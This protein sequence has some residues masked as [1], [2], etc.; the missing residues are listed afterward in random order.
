MTTKGITAI[1]AA[2][3]FFSA[4][5][6]RL[7]LAISLTFFSL[8]AAH[9]QQSMVATLQYHKAELILRDYNASGR[10]DTDA[11]REQL[12]EALTYIGYALDEDTDDAFLWYAKAQV[13]EYL[14]QWDASLSAYKQ[15]FAIQAH[16]ES[17][18]SIA[19]I[20]IEQGEYTEAILMLNSVLSDAPPLNE[21]TF[22]LTEQLISAYIMDNQLTQASQLADQLVE[23]DHSLASS[24]LR[25]ATHALKDQ[26]AESPTDPQDFRSIVEGVFDLVLE[27]D[28]IPQS[29]DDRQ[30]TMGFE[31]EDEKQYL[32]EYYLPGQSAQNWTEVIALRMLKNEHSSPVDLMSE[33]K[34]AVLTAC[35]DSKWSDLNSSQ[36][37]PATAQAEWLTSDSCV[38]RTHY[39]RTEKMV[40]I[41]QGV[42]A[43]IAYTTTN[44]DIDQEQKSLWLSR[45]AE[46]P[47]QQALVV[48]PTN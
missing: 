13:H 28:L 27:N 12:T 44:I 46:L 2:G 34:K 4:L 47:L 5:P 15:S 37:E 31:A 40:Q 48:N 26:S 7:A 8:S 20:T 38:D 17:A 18:L 42:L 45:I 29:L 25:I 6:W 19:T 1:P 30:W 24:A 33:S 43:S 32:R 10:P 22:S 23:N 35:S 3:N 39:Y 16:P 11:G 21:L 41:K 36:K 9:A 14:A